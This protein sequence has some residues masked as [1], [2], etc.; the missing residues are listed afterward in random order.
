MSAASQFRPQ[1]DIPVEFENRVRRRPGVAERYY[2]AAFVIVGEFGR[3]RQRGGN[4]RHAAGHVLH[5]LGGQRV[6]EVRLVVQQR[7]AGQR[8]VQHRHGPVVGHEAPPAQQPGRLCRLDQR[9]GAGVGRADE[10]HRDA[11]RA[12]QPGHLDHVAG[13]PV[14]RQVPDV[15]HPPVIAR[16][17]RELRYVGG[18]GDHR[19]RPAEP[20]QVAV[21]GQDQVHVALGQPFRG[22]HRHGGGRPQRAR[23]PRLGAERGGGVLVHIPDHRRPP[24]PR[25][26]REQQLGVVDQHQV[27]AGGVP[28]EGRTGGQDRPGTASSP[29][30]RNRLEVKRRPRPFGIKILGIDRRDVRDLV[31]GVEQGAYLPVVDARVGRMMNDRAH[32]YPHRRLPPGQ[33]ASTC[34]VAG[35]LGTTPRV[36][37]RSRADRAIWARS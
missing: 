4:D 35:V 3:G 9:P 20:C 30:P 23:Q 19:V 31:T 29:R 28:G 26:Q 2:E 27:R 6:P 13:A 11:V 22:A 36:S 18:V 37:S 10:L 34:G 33:R 24:A 5:Y 12:H 8:A 1:R 14:R 7:Q 21:L 15:H 16:R 32:H 25:G 17:G